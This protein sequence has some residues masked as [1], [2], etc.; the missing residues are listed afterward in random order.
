MRGLLNI[1]ILLCWSKLLL[2]T[3]LLI[4]LIAASLKNLISTPRI[5]LGWWLR[6]EV[7]LIEL[8]R[9]LVRKGVIWGIGLTRLIHSMSLSNTIRI[10]VLWSY[11][12]LSKLLSDLVQVGMIFKGLICLHKSR[13]LIASLIK[14]TVVF[15]VIVKCLLHIGLLLWMHALLIESKVLLLHKEG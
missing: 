3:H 8:R 7:I 13:L 1:K 2:L 4:I 14:I 10:L 15:C 11:A 9:I 6:N 5:M 12:H